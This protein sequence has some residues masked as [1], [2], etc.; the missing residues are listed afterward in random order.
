V[1]RPICTFIDKILTSRK[2]RAIEPELIPCC[3]KY[4]ID[5]VIYNPLAGGLFSGKIKS[6]D[7]APAEGRFAQNSKMG[8]MY[9]SRYFKNANFEALRLVEGVAQKHNLTLLE[10]A[11][12]WCVHHSELKTRA[13]GGNDGVIIGVSSFSQLE[14]NLT[15]LEKGPLPEEV[16]SALDEAWMI[17]KASA[18]VYFR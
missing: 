11:L 8:E 6:A 7:I 10:I 9:R 14:S 1:S 4:K 13:K 16:V 12:R 5:I 17:A 18:P 2:A 15:D 3:R